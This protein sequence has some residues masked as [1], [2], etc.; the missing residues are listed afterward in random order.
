M[1]RCFTILVSLILLVILL[2][3]FQTTTFAASLKGSSFRIDGSHR[4]NGPQKA[5]IKTVHQSQKHQTVLRIPP[6]PEQIVI[7]LIPTLLAVAVRQQ[8][9]TIYSTRNHRSA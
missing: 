7:I 8:H 5:K 3:S 1:K 4:I 6:A 9:T 2:L